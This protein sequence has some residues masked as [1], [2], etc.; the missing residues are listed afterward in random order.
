MKVRP[1]DTETVIRAARKTKDG[2][3][4][5]ELDRCGNQSAL[6]KAIQDAIGQSGEARMLTSRVRLE[7][8][9]M[10]CIATSAQVAEAVR[11]ELGADFN[12]ELKVT[13]FAPNT[14]ELKMAIVELDDK[15]ACKLLEKGKLRVGWV[16]CR[17]R[18]RTDVQRCF[19]CLGYGHRK[20]ECK[21]PD[22]SGLCW[23]CGQQGHKA[24]ACTS[25]P[26]C[27]LCSD[28]A[29]DAPRPEHVP[30]SGACKA[31]RV[32]LDK[33]KGQRK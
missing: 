25:K 10:D 19:R 21:G 20:Q 7:V 32:A 27:F 26:R 15:P 9:D 6:Q 11:R 18:Q 23:K 33:A 13:V 17:L 2:A 12:G 4:L 28:E 30:G 14:R 16:R 24:I 3:I 1:E 5:L 22:R 29:K 8:L 31:F